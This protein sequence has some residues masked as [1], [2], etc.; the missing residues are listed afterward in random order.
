[1]NKLFE[2]HGYREQEQIRNWWRSGWET[3]CVHEW[4]KSGKME[5]A[6][7][8]SGNGENVLEPYEGADAS[9]CKVSVSV[10]CRLLER[11]SWS[12]ERS[13]WK[14]SNTM[15]EKKIKCQFLSGVHP[16]RKKKSWRKILFPKNVQSVG[17]PSPFKLCVCFAS[18]QGKQCL[19]K[20][21]LENWDKKDPLP[22][23]PGWDKIQTFSANRVW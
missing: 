1:M 3:W 23:F 5:N 8:K 11:T 2:V 17:L 9:F 19:G 20:F 13:L 21:W 7:I 10:Q 22:W 14:P 16:N 15:W 18:F 12:S 6:K 4:I